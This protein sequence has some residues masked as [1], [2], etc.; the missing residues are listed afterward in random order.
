[1]KHRI[2]TPLE[3]TNSNGGRKGF[4]EADATRYTAWAYEVKDF[5]L[6]KV[7]YVEDGWLVICGLTRLAYLF[8]K[9]GVLHW[10]Y[11]MEKFTLNQ[12]D[13]ENVAYV[14]GGLIDR[15]VVDYEVE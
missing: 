11:I 14:I 1:M 3:I 10:S 13:A 7:G 4:F 12:I 15:E 6:Q 2:S 8:Q 9:A 5:K